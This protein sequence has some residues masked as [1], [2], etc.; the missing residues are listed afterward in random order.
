[1]T[2]ALLV[3]ALLSV[4]ALAQEPAVAQRL[5]ARE[6][7]AL[8]PK[9]SYSVGIFAPL[10]YVVAE[11]V[12]LQTFPLVFF[13]SP[14]LAAKVRHFESGAWT[15]SGQYALSVPTPAMLLSR[16]YLFPTRGTEIGWYL[17]P[18]AGL[19]VSHGQPERNILTLAAE[20]A[21]GVPLSSSE[22]TP[23]G[24]P[25]PLDMLF[26]PVTAGWRGRLGF[27]EDL[28][29]TEALRTRIYGDLYLHRADP[30]AFTLRAGVAADL[31][32]GKSSRISAGVV[33]WNS[34]QGALD[35]AT[36]L[37]VRSNDLY[38]TVDLIIAGP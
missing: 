14:N 1:M 16:G 21:V 6:S 27:I 35:P 22:V 31:R 13:I 36:G 9:G 8:L 19:L 11:G 4:P 5:A 10:E 20:F 7:A 24:A 29:W 12:E 30:S 3:L 38:P 32:V 37:P 25:A 34:R 23:M 15:I 18:R 28:S 33:W 26:A 2:R 17:V